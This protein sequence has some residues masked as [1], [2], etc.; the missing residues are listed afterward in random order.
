MEKKHTYKKSLELL[1]HKSII[2]LFFIFFIGQLNT[3]A[4]MTPLFSQYDMNAYLINPAMAGNEGYTSINLTAREQWIGLDKSPRTHA[5]GAETRLM[6]TS[7]IGRKAGIRRRGS[8][9]KRSGRVGIAG[10]LFSDMNGHV[11]RLGLNLTY[12]YHINFR[13]SQLSF[14]LSGI[15]YQY[16]MN[17][18]EFIPFTPD[19]N[20][21]NSLDKAYFLPDATFG[22]VY[23]HPQFYAGIA[24]SQLFET[25]IYYLFADDETQYEQIE[26]HYMINGGY[27]YE[28]PATTEMRVVPSFLL[29]TNDN[30]NTQID[31][32]CKL[33]LYNRYWIGMSYRTGGY[34]SLVMLMGM[35]VM[36]FYFGY[37]Y[38][39]AFSSIMHYNNFGSHEIVVALKFGDN[40]RRY[41]WLNRY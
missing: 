7:F 40:A 12:A 29:K 23:R 32:N 30:F 34:G 3:Q 27:N 25:N 41:R 35:K 16:K 13:Y 19:D 9:R 26:R 5:L 20:F 11:N 15:M 28:L 37:S 1:F 22:L 36:N 39:Y 17:S 24:T 4:Q 6:R 31:L 38:D 10:Y 18:S 8:R 21:L 33:F 2:A 14:G